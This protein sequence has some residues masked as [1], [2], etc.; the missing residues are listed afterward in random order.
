[1]SNKIR[2]NRKKKS[3][4]GLNEGALL[5]RMTNRIRQSLELQE[6]LSATVREVRSF[7]GTDRV[8]I[9]RFQPDGVGQVIAESIHE[10]R[11]PSLLG[12]FFPA[13]DIPPA[14]RELF[15]KARPRVIVDIPLQETTFS[16]LENPTAVSNFTLEDVSTLPVEEILRRPVDPCHVQYLTAM[17]VQSSMVIPILHQQEL[18]GL[19]V[20]HHAEPK[21]FSKK[22]LQIVQLVADQ[23]SIAI[24]QS[25]LLSQ[26]REQAHREMV[27]NQISRLLH[28]PLPLY[29]ILQTVLEQIVNV[30]EGREVGSTYCRMAVFLQNNFIP[31]VTNPICQTVIRAWKSLGFGDS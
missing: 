23:V 4:Q 19:L 1:M 15:I 27:I 14:S 8:K 26:T 30:V 2:L 7:L 20:S 28:A 24:S 18:W 29:E 10:G 17:G 21:R 12:L 11:L 5:N 13:G 3:D 31:W 16:R 9:Y 6:I 25:F 22:K